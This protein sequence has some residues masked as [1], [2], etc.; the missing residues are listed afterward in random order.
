MTANQMQTQQQATTAEHWNFATV[1]ACTACVD[2]LHGRRRQ[3]VVQAALDTSNKSACQQQV[4]PHLGD[5][6]MAFCLVQH[7]HGRQ[8]HSHAY[9]QPQLSQNVL[10]DLGSCHWRSCSQVV[11]RYHGCVA[12]LA[13]QTEQGYCCQ[14]SVLGSCERWHSV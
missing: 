10:S 2:L 14:A 1:E 13:L 3:H 9:R 4:K 5:F 11:H 7:R 8:C 6:S 12:V